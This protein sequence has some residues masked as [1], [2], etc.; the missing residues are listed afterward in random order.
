MVS[1]PVSTMNVVMA[2]HWDDET[3]QMMEQMTVYTTNGWR[4]IVREILKDCWMVCMSDE[5]KGGW[6]EQMKGLMLVYMTDEY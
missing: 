4:K 6:K 1:K 3:E 5:E 2:S